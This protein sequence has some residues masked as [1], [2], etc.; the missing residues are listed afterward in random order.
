MSETTRKAEA[1]TA[2]LIQDVKTISLICILAWFIP[3]TGHLMLKGPRRALTFLI[4]ITFLFYWGLGLG[5]KIY[6][7]DPQQPLTFFAM[8]AQMG[9]GL[10]YIVA[11]YIASYAQGHPAGVLYAFAESFRFGQG[12]IESF[13]FEYGNTF[14]IVAGLLN[15]LVILDAY[16]IAVGRK[17]DRN[18]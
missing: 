15:F 6:Q 13:S 3:G 5:A 1:A 11:R 2:P 8:I 18:A 14:S 12:N 7:Y 16:D 4:L 9:M 17:K 10:P